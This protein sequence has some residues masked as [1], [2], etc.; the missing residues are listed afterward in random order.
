MTRRQISLYYREAL[1]L[2]GER[3]EQDIKAAAI[4]AHADPRKLLGRR[5]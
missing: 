1:R 3:Y 2:E 5:N 4:G